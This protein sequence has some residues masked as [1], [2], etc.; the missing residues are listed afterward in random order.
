MSKF[1][2]LMLILSVLSVFTLLTFAEVLERQPEV[3]KL[4]KPNKKRGLPV[5]EALAVR[6]SVTEWSDKDLSIQDLSDL[7][8]AANGINRPEIG[9]RTAP[10]SQNAQDVDIYV[11]MKDGVYLYDA[12]A[13]S[14][15]HL[16]QGDHRLL[17]FPPRPQQPPTEQM[18]VP[19]VVLLLV[20][21][22]SRFRFGPEEL[23]REWGAIDVG[24]VSQNISIFCAA[25]GLGTR[26]RASMDREKIRTLL[27][28][29]E[30]QFPMLN[31]PVGHKKE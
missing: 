2:L 9:K 19:P 15:V 11:F 1:I 28:L 27:K 6:A 16:V 10:S 20:T 3:I 4:P 14:L 23:K 25:V 30:T 29:K 8:W 24:I 22:I 17:F 21:D 5:M 12:Q 13:H 7:L 26:P 31:H 18:T